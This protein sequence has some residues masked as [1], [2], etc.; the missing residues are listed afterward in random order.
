MCQR[1][2]CTFT[3]LNE[4]PA[5][6]IDLTREFIIGEEQAISAKREQDAARAALPRGR[7]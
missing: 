1:M 2:R 5:E 7:R 4:Q 3:E 6:V